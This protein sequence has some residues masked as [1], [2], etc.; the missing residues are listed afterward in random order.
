MT[1]KQPQ[2]PSFLS[3][4]GLSGLIFFISDVQAGVGPFLAL[5]LQYDLKWDAGAIGVALA[6]INI[7]AAVSQIPSGLLVDATKFKRLLIA[8][9]IFLISMGCLVILFLPTQLWII[10]AQA[11]MGVSSTLIGPTIAAITLGLV[12]RKLFPKRTAIN[13]SWN[14][15]GNLCTA[16]LAGLTGYAFGHAWILYTVITFALISA[17]FLFMIQPQEI[18]YNVARELAEPGLQ[19]R[20]KPI[21][22]WKVLKTKPFIIFSISVILFHLANA[23]QLPLVGELLAQ[24]NPKTDSLFMASSIILAQGVMIGVAYSL[25]FF[26]NQYGRKQ[27][28]LIGF[29]ALPIRALLYTLT[30]DPFFLLAVQLLDGIGAG[31]FGVIAVVIVSDLVKGTGRFNFSLSVVILCQGIGASLSNV[32]AGYSVNFFGFD[33]GFL[34]LALFA[35]IGLLFFWF[36]M[37][38]TKDNNDR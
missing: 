12:G 35:A 28:F 14:H 18:D 4:L 7:A 9:A 2:S 34:T 33:G 3:I 24:K 11:S 30:Q 15:A 21:S 16:L 17:T 5:Y 6:T 10:L 8:I 36:F 1:V 37:P 31:I 22:V 29:L 13:E 20:A 26:V 19:G 38:E 27:I 25:K 23:A 32:L